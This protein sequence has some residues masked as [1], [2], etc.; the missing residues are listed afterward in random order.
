LLYLGAEACQR[1]DRAQADREAALLYAAE[2]RSLLEQAVDVLDAQPLPVE[3]GTWDGYLLAHQARGL[4][5]SEPRAAGQALCEELHATR[6][7][8]RSASALVGAKQ[9]GDPARLRLCEQVLQEA[10]ASLKA[11]SAAAS[12]ARLRTPR[13][14]HR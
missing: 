10:V 8:A 9:E 1:V 3:G 7:V 4:L 2:L 5:R 12:D 13:R 11:A 14:G 6:L